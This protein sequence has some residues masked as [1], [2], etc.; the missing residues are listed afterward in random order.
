MRVKSPAAPF[1]TLKR[2]GLKGRGPAELCR[3]RA[4]ALYTISCCSH[5]ENFGVLPPNPGRC[6]V[7]CF[8]CCFTNH[9]QTPILNMRPTQGHLL[10][11]LGGCSIDF[12]R[13]DAVKRLSNEDHDVT[14]QPGLGERRKSLK[15]SACFSRYTR[16][17][18]RKE[19][20]EGTQHSRSRRQS[21]CAVG[22]GS[23]GGEWLV[24]AN[25]PAR[26]FVRLH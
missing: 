3:R 25:C 5:S 10:A 16:E 22:R 26:G 17:Q 14:V 7:C 4:L 20:E 11:P 8:D 6:F 18:G 12:S 21:L 15:Q 13:M 9:A 23:R 19:G 1:D 2:V 24:V